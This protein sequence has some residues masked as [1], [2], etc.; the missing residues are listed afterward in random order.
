MAGE[1][2]HRTLLRLGPAIVGATLLLR[3]DS[4]LLFL[5]PL[6][7]EQPARTDGRTRHLGLP[8]PRLGA[9]DF[10][11]NADSEAGKYDFSVLL[12]STPPGREPH[13]ASPAPARPPASALHDATGPPAQFPSGLAPP[14][15]ATPPTAAKAPEIDLLPEVEPP[16]PQ[17]G[18]RTQSAALAAVLEM[19]Q[20]AF[21]PLTAPVIGRAGAAGPDS[22]QLS[23]SRENPPGSL[24][25]EGPIRPDAAPGTLPVAISNLI[26]QLPVL[27]V[28]EFRLFA[29]LDEAVEETVTTPQASPPATRLAPSSMAAQIPVAADPGKPEDTSLQNG[30]G[31]ASS[32]LQDHPV[33]VSGEAPSRLALLEPR[34]GQP[35][36]QVPVKAS[37]SP[38]LTGLAPPALLAPSLSPAVPASGAA[39]TLAHGSVTVAEARLAETSSSPERDVSA[40]G[41]LDESL[42]DAS[43]VR[44]KPMLP[45]PAFGALSAS[46]PETA[47]AGV[48]GVARLAALEDKAAGLPGGE[49]QSLSQPA[50]RPVGGEAFK[51][52]ATVPAGQ[53]QGAHVAAAELAPTPAASAPLASAGKPS[54]GRELP[55]PRF[56]ATDV[57]P[58]ASPPGTGEPETAKLFPGAD[59]KF[60]SP[61]IAAQPTPSTADK[62]ALTDTSPRLASAPAPS[63][64]Y[65]D[66]LI[67]EIRTQKGATSDTVIAYGSRA[68]VYLP[69]GALARLL[70]LAIVVSDDGHYASGWFLHEDRKLRIDLRQWTVLVDGKEVPLSH[71]DAVAFEGEL[72]L[73][74]EFY[75]KL[76]PLTMSVSLRGQSV[77]I[78]TLEPFPFEER[79]ER[80]MQRKKLES[81][82]GSGEPEH[83][84]REDTPWR[85]FT[86]PA[87]DVELRAASD[88]NLGE[89]FESDLRVAGD[90]AFMTARAYLSGDTHKGLTAARLELGRRD[91]DAQLLGPLRATE[92]QLGDVYVPSMEMGLRGTSGRGFFVTNAPLERASIFEKID[93]RGDLETGYEVELYR[94]NI[95]IGSTRDAVNGQFEF[96]QIPV[97]YGLNVFRL[98]FYGPQGQRREE[99]RRISVGDGRLAKGQFVYTLGAAQ[100]AT[101]LFDVQPPDFSPPQDYRSWR[102]SAQFEYGVSTAVTALLGGAWFETEGDKRWMMTG[103]LRTGIAG[104]AASLDFGVH[105]GGGKALGLGLGGKLFGT[106]FTLSHTEYRGQA[107]DEVRT[108]NNEIPRRATEFDLNGALRFGDSPGAPS[109][110]FYG[111][112]RRIEFADGRGQTDASLRGSA[113]V[114]KFLLSNTFE[115][116]DSKSLSGVSTSRFSGSFDLASLPGSR[117]QYRATVGYRLAPQARITTVG[118][119]VDR[120]IDDRTLVNASVNHALS[121]DLT[122]IGLSAIRRFERF[123]LGLDGH[124]G[125][126]DKSY[127]VML[128]LGFSLG[129]NPLSRSFFIDSP[130]LA[131]GGAIAVQAYLDRDG[132]RKFGEGDTVL[133]GVRFVSGSAHASTDARG[134]GFLGGLGDGNRASYVVDQESFPDIMM[135]PMTKGVEIVPRAGRIHVSHFGVQALSE[136]EGEALFD[137]GRGPRAV[138]GLS[139]E[140]VDE[141]GET[142]SRSRSEADGFFLFEQVPPGKYIIRIDPG[143]SQRLNIQMAQEIHVS[144]GDESEVLREKVIVY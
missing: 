44:A 9:G 34:F 7:D 138:S 65:D 88:D 4:A 20:P 109:I 103:G 79:I 93:L 68:G 78:T 124:Y 142:V 56:S 46:T 54:A 116:S 19:P 141:K 32:G 137:N 61:S 133:E 122:R 90:L 28:P 86:F 89:R 115:Y 45:E 70:D 80:E 107:I 71:A 132:D 144:V 100:K 25:G 95:L 40:S 13:G 69:L 139:L 128:R 125:I 26:V 27:E 59:P 2:P 105:G 106:T 75:A 30:L 50:A 119:E 49:V 112:F 29:K 14:P 74:D 102:A 84:P 111:R 82:G 98:V 114:S 66:E 131:S 92:F 83:W 5:Q 52:A 63:F 10:S 18:E 16:A 85:A 130:G 136:I 11:R 126:Q 72:Y 21:G 53:P 73:R 47:E 12:L 8:Q 15:L 1:G 117:T 58:A 121:E 41:S 37:A 6:D 97:D 51:K 33:G 62:A 23:E 55:K 104:M 81:Q 43:E 123:N 135:S 24:S 99:V 140:L 67:L 113:R 120:A 91:P 48:P 87:A 39:E 60:F 76:L 64:S 96:L 108:F 3:G 57:Q 22:P 118:L 110:P 35:A 38:D 17:I 134:E 127:G 129:R 42:L 101:N 77:T 36:G 94:N 31:Q 143:Q